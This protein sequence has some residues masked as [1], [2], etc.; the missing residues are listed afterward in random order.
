MNIAHFLCWKCTFN[1]FL[2]QTNICHFL[3]A[4]A[5]FFIVL[6]CTLF[7]L[8]RAPFPTYNLGKCI[9]DIMFPS[10]YTL[11]RMK[12]NPIYKD[13][14]NIWGKL[15]TTRFRRDLLLPLK[16]RTKSWT[17]GITK[18]NRTFLHCVPRSKK[19]S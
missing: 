4:L 12:A 14:E 13:T 19:V 3:E 10:K 6:G 2:E 8:Q 17:G 18:T 16:R 9:R 7:S 1:G 5:I 15:S 11:L